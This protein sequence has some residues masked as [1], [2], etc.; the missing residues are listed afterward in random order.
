VI[1]DPGY[2][3]RFLRRGRRVLSQRVVER[4]LIGKMFDRS[5]T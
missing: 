3:V 5:D 1:L 4:Y 2:I